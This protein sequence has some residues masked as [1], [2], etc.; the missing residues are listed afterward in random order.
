MSIPDLQENV[1]EKE[2]QKM[3]SVAEFLTQQ[4]ERCGKSQVAIARDVG[5]SRSNIITMLKNGTSKVPI[6]RAPAL[7]KAVGLDPAVFLRMV[8][9][10]Y[11]PEILKAIEDTIGVIQPE[12]ANA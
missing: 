12:Q 7:G 10:E 3:L 4:I 1:V 2:D 6:S 9:A 5:Y 8:L 11:Q